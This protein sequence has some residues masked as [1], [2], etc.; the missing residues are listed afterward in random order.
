MTQY[1]FEGPRWYRGRIRSRGPL[2]ALLPPAVVGAV[3]LL[4]LNLGG[5]SLT[6]V[7]GLV[8]GILAAPALLAVGSPISSNSL[9][10]IG[11]AI[12]VVLWL[13]VGFLAARRATRYPMASWGDFWRAYAVLAAGICV[14][15]GIALGVARAAVGDALI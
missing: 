6:G 8:L 13:V 4:L 14:G 2:V 10:P 11:I 9:I 3:A 5:S 1:T 15:A 7:T 12:S